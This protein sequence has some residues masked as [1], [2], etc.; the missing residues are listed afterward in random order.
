MV[1]MGIFVYKI[2]SGGYGLVCGL[3]CLW[4]GEGGSLTNNQM[5]TLYHHMIC[6]KIHHLTQA[7]G[8]EIVQT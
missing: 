2:M 8:Y 3:V 6:I 4:D 1:M 7:L 5:Y